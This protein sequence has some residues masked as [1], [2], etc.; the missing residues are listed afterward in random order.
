LPPAIVLAC[1]IAS[2]STRPSAFACGI[3][4]VGRQSCAHYRLREEALT[5]IR[6]ARNRGFG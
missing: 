3:F 2:F 1:R 6:Y 4:P 5:Q